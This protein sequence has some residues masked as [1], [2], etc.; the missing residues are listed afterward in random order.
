MNHSLVDVVLLF[1]DHITNI[2]VELTL[3]YLLLVILILTVVTLLLLLDIHLELLHCVV[4]T[5]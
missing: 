4:V 1:S 2:A 3:I 5:L